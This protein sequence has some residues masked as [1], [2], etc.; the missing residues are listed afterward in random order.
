MTSAIRG[1]LWTGGISPA[2]R[3]TS[4]PT[5]ILAGM[6]LFLPIVA[7]AQQGER[8]LDEIKTESIH[9]AE[10][11]GYPLIGL[12][13][14]DVREAFEHIHTK[15][16]DEWARAFINV[17]DRYMAEGKAIQATDP[18]G[19]RGLCQGVAPLL[20]RAVAGGIVADERG[21]LQESDQCV[22]DAGAIYALQAGGSPYSV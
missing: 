14:E 20:V 16:K 2:I 7:L 5:P 18:K 8:T 13:P 3:L 12:H 10:V 11:G 17:G 1:K 19:G 4:N 22:S 9:R 6:M 21:G 15:E